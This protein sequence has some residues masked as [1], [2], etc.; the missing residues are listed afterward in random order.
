MSS[1][2]PASL[3]KAGIGIAAYFVFAI[4]GGWFL[5]A[6]PALVHR[7]NSLP[8]GALLSVQA[9]LFCTG[10]PLSALGDLL[11]LKR[12]GVAYLLLWPSFVGLVSGVQVYFFRSRLLRHWSVP[13]AER[14]MRRHQGWPRRSR[15]AAA[16]VL[17]IRSAP[18]LPFL[19]GSLVISMLRDVRLRWVVLLSILGSYLYYSYF[20]LGFL[21]GGGGWL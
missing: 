9:V 14:L 8:T 16:L 13:M 7:L 10:I 5:R 20:A 3:S 11:L 2:P 18:V 1:Q 19:V 4:C 17:F 12:I 15:H 21:L 6:H